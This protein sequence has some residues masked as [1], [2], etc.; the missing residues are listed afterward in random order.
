[1]NT[2]IHITIDAYNLLKNANEHTR[3]IENLTGSIELEATL[4]EIDDYERRGGGAVDNIVSDETMAS[5]L[6][7]FKFEGT[8]LDEEMKRV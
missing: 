6:E 7:H 4:D 2:H 8:L 1:M 3:K 5:L